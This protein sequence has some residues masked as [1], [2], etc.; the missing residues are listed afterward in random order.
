VLAQLL[1]D[2][3]PS[4]DATVTYQG[5][6]IAACW[7][8]LPGGQVGVLDEDGDGGVLPVSAFK[9]EPGT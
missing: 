6:K 1:A 3:W 9:D 2:Y 7:V 4:F 5:R 8:M